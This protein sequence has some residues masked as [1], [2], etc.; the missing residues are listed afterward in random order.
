M[1]VVSRN[2]NFNPDKDLPPRGCRSGQS[3]GVEG[4]PA[5][6]ARAAELAPGNKFVVTSGS[7]ADL[8]GKA[9]MSI[10]GMSYRGVSW[11]VAIDREGGRLVIYRPKT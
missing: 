4:L 10:R 3:Y 2:S 11:K 8:F 6:Y 7:A 5:V 1:L 9:Y